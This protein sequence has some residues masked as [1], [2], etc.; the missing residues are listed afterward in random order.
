MD[1]VEANDTQETTEAAP[2]AAPE[3]AADT[4]ETS[5]RDAVEGVVAEVAAKEGGEVQPGG[6][7]KAPAPAYTP[8]LNFKV[9]DEE[10]KFDDWMT[11]VIT[12]KEQ[13]DKVHRSSTL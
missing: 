7:D 12:S 6:E 1:N 4:G 10:K 8:N 5:I 3:I 2:E 13:E 9:H 11:P